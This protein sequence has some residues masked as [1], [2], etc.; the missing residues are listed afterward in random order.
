MIGLLSR[1]NRTAAVAVHRTAV[2]IG[3]RCAPPGRAKSGTHPR[4]RPGTM[5]LMTPLPAGYRTVEV[6]QSRHR[7]LLVLDT[8]A[9]PSTVTDD[10]LSLIHISE[11]TRPY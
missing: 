7:D 2:Q 3:P 9:F 6:P 5:G 4:R 11:P 1:R 10:Q 8:W